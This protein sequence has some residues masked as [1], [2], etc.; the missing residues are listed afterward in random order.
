VKGKAVFEGGGFSKFIVDHK[1]RKTGR[2][3]GGG[4]GGKGVFVRD[5]VGSGG[6]TT[7]GRE[8]TTTRRSEKNIK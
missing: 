4:R 8:K 2:G 7:S 5:R 1:K 6:A 3:V